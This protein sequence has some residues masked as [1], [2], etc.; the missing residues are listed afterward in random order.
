[1][2]THTGY[3]ISA[4]RK[5][6]CAQKI[7]FQKILLVS[8]AVKHNNVLLNLIIVCLYWLITCFGQLHDHRQVYK[9]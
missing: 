1:M 2:S 5:L 4:H 8:M 9:S 6:K 7:K 3:E